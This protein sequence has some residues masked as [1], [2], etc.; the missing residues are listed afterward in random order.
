MDKVATVYMLAGS[1]IVDTDCLHQYAADGSH[2]TLET[3]GSVK[4]F[5]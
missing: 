5:P 4:T 2:P 1:E 3:L